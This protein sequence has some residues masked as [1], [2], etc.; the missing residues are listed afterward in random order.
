MCLSPRSKT[1][2]HVPASL[3]YHQRSLITYDVRTAGGSLTDAILAMKEAGLLDEDPDEIDNY[4]N[5]A[6]FSYKRAKPIFTGIF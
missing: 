4:M 3:L 5:V 1:A 2:L 6:K